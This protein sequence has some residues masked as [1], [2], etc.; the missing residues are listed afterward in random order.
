[1]A[2]APSTTSAFDG[3]GNVWFKIKDI[4]PT[5]S[6]G[7]VTWPLQRRLVHF[8][9]RSE[10][11]TYDQRRIRAISLPV[12]PMET[13]CSEF[14]SSLFTTRTQLGFLRYRSLSER[15]LTE[16]ANPNAVLY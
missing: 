5:F 14:S 9:V 15:F 3:S 12:F 10:E 11:L 6:N 7:Q 16:W 13:I 1:M 4:G 2:K 8:L